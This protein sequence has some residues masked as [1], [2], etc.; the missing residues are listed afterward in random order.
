MATTVEVSDDTWTRLN[1]RKERG[2][3]FDDVIRVMLE[4]ETDQ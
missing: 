4:S 3:S 2:Q 1:R